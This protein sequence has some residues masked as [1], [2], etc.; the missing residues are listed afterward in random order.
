MRNA[1]TD[2]RTG[3]FLNQKFELR[4]LLESSEVHDTYRALDRTNA[5]EV[6]VRLLR[7]EF[8]LQSTVVQ[9]FVRAPKTVAGFKHPNV[10]Q[11]FSV[12]SD[13]TGIPYVVEEFLRGETLTQMLQNFPG[14][15]PLGVAMAVVSPVLEAMAAAHKRGIIHGRL[16]SEHVM[17]AKVGS[18]SVPKV[19]AFGALGPEPR[20]AASDA[21]RLAP[22]LRNGKAKPDLSSDVWSLGALLYVTLGGQEPE[23]LRGV[24][25]SLDELAPHLPSEI[26]ELVERCLSAIPRARPKAA[27]EVRDALVAACEHMRVGETKPLLTA[28]PLRQPA[29]VPRRPT[30]SLGRRCEHGPG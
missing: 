21:Q 1:A 22:E 27:G 19:I 30:C 26:V 29:A 16:D 13:E 10:A 4:E 11:V 15:M 3:E 25:T 12:E 6:K 17:I 7:P 8:A 14:G 28:T 2:T 24:H 5:S 20:G 18:G 9:G 23:T